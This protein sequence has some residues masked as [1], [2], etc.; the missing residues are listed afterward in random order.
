MN[1]Y[2]TRLQLL[3]L[4][5]VSSVKPHTLN[6][7]SLP[8]LNTQQNTEMTM[9]E[10]YSVIMKVPHEVFGESELHNTGGFAIRGT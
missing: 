9:Y 8:I 1:E 3:S 5:A 2:S 4:M 7:D 10:R 6:T